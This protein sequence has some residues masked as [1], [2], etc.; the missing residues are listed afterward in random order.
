MKTDL[1]FEHRWDRRSGFGFTGDAFV[2]FLS[3][4]FNGCD[5]KM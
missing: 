3:I 1:V 4:R 2:V 5:F